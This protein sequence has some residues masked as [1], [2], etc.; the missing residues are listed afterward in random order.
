[1]SRKGKNGVE[2][3]LAGALDDALL[4]AAAVAAV[5]GDDVLD[6]GRVVAPILAHRADQLALRK[7]QLPPQQLVL[8]LH[9]AHPLRQ[10]RLAVVEAQQ[11]VWV[12]L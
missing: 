5:G 6:G 12:G 4:L 9:L 3:H 7:A 10:P 8:L 2:L 11:V 1:M